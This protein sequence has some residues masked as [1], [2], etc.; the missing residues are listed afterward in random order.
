VNNRTLG[1]GRFTVGISSGQHPTILSVGEIWCPS[2]DRYIERRILVTTRWSLVIP[3]L[4]AK[5]KTEVQGTAVADSY[6]SGDPLYSTSSRYDPAK[7]RDRSMVGCIQ[8]QLLVKDSAKVYGDVG[9]DTGVITVTSPAKVGDKPWVNGGSSG[10]QSGHS[11]TDLEMSF[12]DVSAPALT[13]ITSIP[14]SKVLSNANYKVVDYT[15]ASGTLLVRSNVTLYVEQTIYFN[16][17]EL[18]IEPGGH[19]D[20][21]FGS[22]FYAQGT[23]KLNTNGTPD[24]LT[25]L[26]VGPNAKEVYLQDTTYVTGTIYAPHAK[27]YVQGDSQFCGAG[28]CNELVLQGLAKFHYDE[29]LARTAQPYKITSWN[30]L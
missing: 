26:G 1:D 24:Q 5:T 20:L 25:I 8:G 17:G 28:A 3:G 27:M 11:T 22:Q 30:E 7:Y 4:V 10:L 2:A 16:G 9:T 6:D 29:M 23:S 14:A 21:Y 13:W 15:L 12:P 18:V 19:L